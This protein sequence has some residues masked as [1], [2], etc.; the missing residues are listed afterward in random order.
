[1]L[2]KFKSP[3]NRLIIALYAFIA[4]LGLN[5]DLSPVTSLEN[6]RIEGYP[7]TRYQEVTGHLSGSMELIATFFAGFSGN[8][9]LWLCIFF[10][11]C[12][13][14]YRA[15]IIGNPRVRRYSLVTAATFS[16][17]YIIGFSISKY[18]GFIAVTASVTAFLKCLV[19]FIGITLVFFALL[20]IFFEKATNC[21]FNDAKIKRTQIFFAT[22][23]A[24]VWRCAI[25][26]ICWLPYLIVYLP[27]FLQRDTAS[28]IAQAMGDSI[29]SNAHPIFTTLLFGIF[30]RFGMLLGSANIGILLYSLFQMIIV[31]AAFSYVLQY[32]AKQN[33]HIY[34]QTWT[35]LFFMLYPVN[36]FYSITMWKD[37][38]FSVVF[39]LLTLK[40]IQMVSQPE[41]FF[42]SKKNVLA[43]SL[44][45]VTLFL[46]RHNGLYILLV[47]L[48]VLLLVFRRYW[49]GFL[50][51]IGIVA[52]SFVSMQIII[53]ALNIRKGSV[54]EALSI[55]IQQ[56]ARTVSEHGDELPDNDKALIASIMPY[57]QLPEI[58]SPTISDPVKFRF[59]EA[60]FRAETG[61]YISL[62]VRLCIKYP[63]TY[64]EAFLCQTHGY[65][66]PDIDYWIVTR[67]FWQNNY[68]MHHW[69]IVPA[70]VDNAFSGIFVF[71]VFPAISML[72]SIGF[73][74]WITIIMALILMLKRKYRM[75]L[76]FLPVFLLWLTCIA[77]PVSGM[78]RYIYGLF[79]VLPLLISFAL[80]SSNWC[81]E[82][83]LNET[84]TIG[85][86]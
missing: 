2:N 22:R 8:S 9:V 79:L 82:F 39:M 27:G 10:A 61:K 12:I 32:M 78:F 66:Y 60:V 5:V 46:T 53:I 36:A 49:K 80:Q 64:L 44:L 71:R 43:F 86:G 37:T 11:L 20:A 72:I 18:N 35:L 85:N 55:P 73:A 51:I 68:D 7:I 67:E 28:Q 59:N 75:L 19:A 29:L 24:F 14:F 26:F 69:R 81:D 58:Y 52:I 15:A 42:R 63:V 47:L 84:E 65:W 17:L 4:T 74:V 3:G 21:G 6:F 83:L 1:M 70:F 77:S 45:S 41:G 76:A 38:L 33:I 31:A 40:T 54:R 23:K 56:I 50:T 57:E 34:V 30:I 25:I 48:P 62:W 13:L 16:L